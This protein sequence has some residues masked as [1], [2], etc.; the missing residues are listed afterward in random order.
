MHIEIYIYIFA[1]NS[2]P[3]NYRSPMRLPGIGACWDKEIYKERTIGCI[4]HEFSAGIV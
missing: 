4:W 2:M 3:L 1:T